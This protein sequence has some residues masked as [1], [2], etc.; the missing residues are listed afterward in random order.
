MK[1]F[2][3]YQLWFL[4]PGIGLTLISLYIPAS[5]LYKQ[6]SWTETEAL[7]VEGNERQ[8]GGEGLY[9]MDYTDANRGLH[10]IEVDGE[11]NTFMEG[12]DSKHVRL[13]YDPS[14]PVDY[15]L[16][17]PG[18]FMVL[19]FFPFGLLCCYLG[20][21]SVEKNESDVRHKSLRK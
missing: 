6:I 21:P 10:R 9:L 2:H 13:Y 8:V 17:N 15:E 14:S 4:I 18:R 19:L 20:W 7:I 11:N 16:V 12:T 5:Y 1:Q 3:L